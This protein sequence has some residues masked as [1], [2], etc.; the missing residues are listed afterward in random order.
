WLAGRPKIARHHTGE[1]LARL[2]E[3]L[4]AIAGIRFPGTESVQYQAARRSTVL[5]GDQMRR[6]WDD[7]LAA[8]CAAQPVLLVLEDLHWG[9]LPTVSFLDGAMRNL[10]DAPLMILALGQPDVH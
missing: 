3:F 8:E 6:A 10:R 9:D 4:G 2:T 1:E 5:M 7:F